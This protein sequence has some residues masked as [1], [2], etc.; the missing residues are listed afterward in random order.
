M[1]DANQIRLQES[2]AS[3]IHE[4]DSSDAEQRTMDLEQI[5]SRQEESNRKKLSVLVGSGIIQ[6][7]IWGTFFGYMNEIPRC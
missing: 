3:A 5:D 2:R 4:L 1:N 6:L 7:P